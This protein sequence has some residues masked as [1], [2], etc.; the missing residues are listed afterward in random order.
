MARVV[1]SGY[2]GFGNLGDEAILYSMVQAL[3]SLEPELE[4]LVLSHDPA[5]TERFLPVKAVNRWRLLEVAWAL[6][7]SDLLISGGG[8]L[9]QD[10]TSPRS[11]LYYLGILELARVLGRPRMVYAQGLG[12]LK[13]SWARYLTAKVLDRVQL[14]TLRDSN[15]HVL[16]RELGVQHPEV[17]VT[18]DPVLGLKVSAFNLGAGREKLLRLGFKAGVKPLAGFFLRYWLLPEGAL[19]A[20][21]RA[22]DY[23]VD[24]GWGVLFLPLHFPRDVEACWQVQRLMNRPAT[25]VKEKL[26]LEDAVGIISSLDFLVGMRLHAL[27]LGAVLEVPFIGLSYDPKVEAFC[28]QVEQPYLPLNFLHYE[29]LIFIFKRVLYE[30]PSIREGLRRA[31][32]ELRPL[33]QSNA[34]LALKLLGGE[35]YRV[36]SQHG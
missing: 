27:I 2:Y 25:V 36:G 13:R 34:V 4:I 6:R 20:L 7:R 35:K 11:L 22:A 3:K 12:P 5:G 19:E 30:L 8:S 31:V 23:L 15:S 18:A 24:Q 16:L 21:A 26:T 17:K 9:F 28:R 1:L 14:I 33:A 32:E 10:T 29:D